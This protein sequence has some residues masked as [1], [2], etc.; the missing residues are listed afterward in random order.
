MDDF[1]V[2]LNSSGSL[3]ETGNEKS[4][5]EGMQIASLKKLKRSR[6]KKE[7]SLY[8]IGYN[9]DTAVFYMGLRKNKMCPICFSSFKSHTGPSY[10]FYL[11]DTWDP[12]TGIRKGEDP[13]GPI[14]FCADCITQ[15]IFYKV[16]HSKLYF[17]QTTDMQEMYGDALGAGGDFKGVERGYDHPEY[18][19]FRLSFPTLYL[20]N[21]A[22][23]NVITIG[24]K[25][26]DAE[27]IQIDQLL[28]V[29]NPGRKVSL[30]AIKKLY[31][32]AISEFTV[33]I[34]MREIPE[35][36]ETYAKEYKDKTY[37]AKTLYK[38]YKSGWR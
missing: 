9:E 17:P 24:P 11:H 28:K 37:A 16:P 32:T 27:V 12:Y 8:K 4:L 34:N 38:L 6:P 7:T 33:P 26:T 20:H 19:I 25:L 2:T 14:V 31:D 21:G 5:M 35:F 23:Q 10:L 15:S 13:Y 30:G 3:M 1:A 22:D 29:Q 18:N 36:Q